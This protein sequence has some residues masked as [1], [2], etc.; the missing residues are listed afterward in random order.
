MPSLGIETGK[1]YQCPILFLIILNLCLFA[2]CVIQQLAAGLLESIWL[3]AVEWGVELL[4]ND[5]CNGA[6]K[7]NTLVFVSAKN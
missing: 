5:K 7:I 4:T 1:N 3:T 2:L 6:V